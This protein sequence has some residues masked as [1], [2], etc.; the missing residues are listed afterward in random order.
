MVPFGV[1]LGPFLVKGRESANPLEPGTTHR[2]GLFQSL[3]GPL[4]QPKPSEL[5]PT[6]PNMKNILH[7]APN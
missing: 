1:D 3:A 7:S 5:S 2:V 4:N 6:E